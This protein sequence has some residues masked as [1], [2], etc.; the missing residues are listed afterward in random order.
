L[1][2]S[3]L[4]NRK[5]PKSLTFRPKLKPMVGLVVLLTLAGIGVIV[6]DKLDQ[7]TS[8]LPMS[9]DASQKLILK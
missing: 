4:K 7:P 5:R 3:P 1:K 9:S 2:K 6:V 8:K